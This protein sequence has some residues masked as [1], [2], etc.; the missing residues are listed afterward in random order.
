M[1]PTQFFTFL[2]AYCTKGQAYSSLDLKFME[3]L[4]YRTR[5]STFPNWKAL[6]CSEPFRWCRES[7]TRSFFRFCSQVMIEDSPLDFLGYAHPDIL[8]ELGDTKLH[9]FVDCT[10]SVVPTF[11]SQVLVLM[12]YFSKYDLYVPVYFVLMQVCTYIYYYYYYTTLTYHISYILHTTTTTTTF[13][14]T[15]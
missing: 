7:D 8:F 4:V 13:T 15:T 2:K 11:F 10:F 14:T 1:I 12:V 6:V 9:G 5:A 3:N